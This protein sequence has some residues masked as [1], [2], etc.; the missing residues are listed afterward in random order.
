MSHQLVQCKHRFLRPCNYYN[1]NKPDEVTVPNI[2][3]ISYFFFFFINKQL[4]LIENDE[5]QLKLVNTTA[6]IS[7]INQCYRAKFDSSRLE[8]LQNNQLVFIRQQMALVPAI[9]TFRLQMSMENYFV[10]KLL[11]FSILQF[12][13]NALHNLF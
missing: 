1:D 11:K 8:Q 7:S 10:V 13:I 5:I 3:I 9:T 12:E 6:V 4:S 2:C